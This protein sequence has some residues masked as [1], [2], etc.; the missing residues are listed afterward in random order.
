[1]ASTAKAPVSTQVVNVPNVLTAMRLVLSIV[2]FVLIGSGYYT[3]ALVTFIV[4]AGTDWVDGYWARKYGQVTQL[5][6]IFD[7][8]V[9][10]IIICGTFT[11]LCSVPGSGMPAWVAVLVF[12]REMLVTALRSALEG[13]GADFSASWSGKLKMGFQCAAAVGSL[14]ALQLRDDDGRTLWY[15]TATGVPLWVHY[16]LLA[17]MWLAVISTVQS[18]VEY[19]AKAARMMRS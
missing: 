6:R 14:L 7:P 16:G 9:D 1:M 13:K 10:K 5:G 8:F 2:V 15:G 12:A 11:F 17:A 18:G 3:A 4:A 19:I